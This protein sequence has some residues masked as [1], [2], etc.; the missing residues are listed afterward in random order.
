M[1]RAEKYGMPKH[2]APSGS[3]KSKR[4]RKE[5]QAAVRE[6]TRQR[7]AMRREAS[8]R[9]ASNTLA[10]AHRRAI[11]NDRAVSNQISVEPPGF[12]PEEWR[13]QS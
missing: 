13:E 10:S 1:V 12:D 3:P 5:R 8:A 9:M 7:E 4:L 6:I 11:E 2:K